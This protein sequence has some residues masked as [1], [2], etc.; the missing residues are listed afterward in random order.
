MIAEY[1]LI[2]T[3]RLQSARTA[4]DGEEIEVL[5]EQA[6]LHRDS[7]LSEAASLGVDV[8]EHRLN[9]VAKL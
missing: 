7:V 5:D 6:Q 2:I 4:S 9:R 1:Q 3:F 8:T